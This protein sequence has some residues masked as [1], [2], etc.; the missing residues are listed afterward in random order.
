MLAHTYNIIIERVI[1]APGHG[2][3]VVC[4]LNYTETLFLYMLM[5]TAKITGVAAY[6]PHM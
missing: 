6:E 4:G 5:T 1:G 3:K 2:R